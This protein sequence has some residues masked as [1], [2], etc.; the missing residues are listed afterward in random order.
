MIVQW[1]KDHNYQFA[2]SDHNTL[3]DSERWYALTESDRQHKVLEKYIDPLALGGNQ[4]G[5]KFLPVYDLKHL[6]STAGN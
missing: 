6:M 2:I 1:Y 4:G 5:H 3:A